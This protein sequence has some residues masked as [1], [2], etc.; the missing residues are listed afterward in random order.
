M[1]KDQGRENAQS[2]ASTPNYDA[3][4]KNRFHS[5]GA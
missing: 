2:E 5:L 3:P 4:K 1:V